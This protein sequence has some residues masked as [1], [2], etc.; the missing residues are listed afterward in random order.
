MK[1]AYFLLPA[2]LLFGGKAYAQNLFFAQLYKHDGLTFSTPLSFSQTPSTLKPI[3][4]TFGTTET[5]EVQPT[6]QSEVAIETI[7]TPTPTP[8]PTQI[9]TPTSTPIPTSTPTPTPSPRP[10]RDNGY[11]DVPSSLS[12]R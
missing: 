5:I 11:I 8:S 10:I 9:P 4:L 7:I 3:S 6:N 2:L 12:G 1:I